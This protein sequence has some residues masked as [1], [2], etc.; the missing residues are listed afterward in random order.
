METFQNILN[1]LS[2]HLT[3]VLIVMAFLGILIIVMIVLTANR[4]VKDAI[5][6]EA[7]KPKKK[8]EKPYIPTKRMPPIGGRLTEKLS[9][10]GFFHVS[11]LSLS[12]LRALEY[13]R[14]VF[15]GTE[16]KYRLPWYLVLGASESGKNT[17]FKNA[18]LRYRAT[19]PDLK[20]PSDHP[21]LK[22]WFYNKGILLQPRGDLF[23]NKRG[24]A[25]ND[26]SRWRQLIALVARYRS[27]K[28]INGII[29]CI[30]ASEIYGINAL[31]RDELYDRAKF[32]GQKLQALQKDL[33]LRLPVYVIVTKCDTVRG[34]Q[35]V[36][37]EIPKTNIF[38]MLGWSNP[39]ALSTTY[40]EKWLDEG[41]DTLQNDIQKIQMEIYTHGKISDNREN[42]F[43]FFDEVTKLKDPLKIYLNAI[44]E[45]SYEEYLELRG[46]Y[47]TGDS[48]FGLESHLDSADVDDAKN[49]EDKTSAEA[50][51]N[52]V[53]SVYF[54]NDLLMEKVFSEGGLSEPA[55]SRLLSANR[56]L[57]V[58]KVSLAS[59]SAIS[60]I[61]LFSAYERLSHYSSKMLPVISNMTVMLS[62]HVEMSPETSQATR[63]DFEDQAKKLIEMMDHIH[64]AKFSSLF[65]PASWFS[66]FQENLTHS[67]KTAYDKIIIRSIYYDIIMRARGLI[68]LHPD[69]SMRSATL[70]QLLKPTT[71]KEFETLVEFLNQLK[72]ISDAA[73]KFNTISTAST[74]EV[75]NDLVMFTFN[76][77]L[78]KSFFE[79]YHRF[80]DIFSTID[81]PPIDFKKDIEK[82]RQAFL[83]VYVFFING[84]FN[85][86]DPFSI[87]GRLEYI[88]KT[89]SER[90][91]EALPDLKA[92]LQFSKELKDGIK[93]LKEPGKNWIDAPFFNPDNTDNPALT[94]PFG[95]FIAQITES[96]L[97]GKGIVKI[98]ADQTAEVFTLFQKNLQKNNKSLLK[99]EDIEDA[100]E[101]IPTSQGLKNL[102]DALNQLFDQVFMRPIK[103]REF[104]SDI[105][106]NKIVFW[107][108][109]LIKK[110]EE[111]AKAHDEYALKALSKLPEKLQPIVRELAILNT[112]N[113][114]VT[115]IAKAQT[116]AET[117]KNLSL[118]QQAEETLRSKINDLK[119]V[120][121]SFLQLLDV[122]NRGQMGP[123]YLELRNLLAPLSFQLLQ[124][125][126]EVFQSYKT[127]TIKDGNFDWWDG[128]LGCSYEAFR[129][130]DQEDLK[131][132]LKNQ[133]DIT[134]RWAIDFADLM[135]RFL[136]NDLVKDAPMDR[137]LI[138]KW[139]RLIEQ[140]RLYDKQIPDS[141]LLALEAFIVND[142]SKLSL[143]NIFDKIPI[144]D[145]A[146]ES[147][148][149]FKQIL[150]DIKKGMRAQAEIIKRKQVVKN[151][152]T[153]VKIFNDT[154]AQRFPFVR[155]APTRMETEAEPE[156][157]REF[158]TLYKNFGNDPKVILDQVH[159]MGGI[160]QNVLLF[161][162]RME[163][164][165]EF[166]ADYLDPNSLNDVPTFNFSVDFRTNRNAELGANLVVDWSF[167]AEEGLYI[168]NH[169]KER[170]GRWEFGEPVEFVFRWP[171]GIDVVPVKDRA[172]PVMS[173]ED[174]SAIFRYSQRWALLWM[175]RIQNA[176]QDANSKT[177]PTPYTLRFD[178]PLGVRKK[179]RIFNRITIL[180]PPKGKGAGKVL[181]VP[182]FPEQA[183]SLPEA[184]EETLT[185]PV[186]TY[187]LLREE[188]MA[189]DNDTEKEGN[190]SV[191][192]KSIEE[193]KDDSIEEEKKD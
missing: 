123:I 164:I 73:N 40:N 74:G 9:I 142:M 175:L 111:L 15:K 119:E 136:T 150:I 52:L 38:N 128:R 107:D 155:G 14:S 63:A 182:P 154:L 170:T 109:K 92:L 1:A 149:Y 118:G 87:P 153:L 124:R 26:E 22:W 167:S 82:I 106:P 116:I 84:L 24:A 166:F 163:K 129:V 192:K 33:G 69:H 19:Q 139:R 168:T 143:K 37:Q 64:Q 98:M 54:I 160:A 100:V 96:P 178:V 185:K 88:L 140:I 158:F 20:L 125:V 132:Y 34:F 8:E 130:K 61:G 133:A 39:Y 186:L 86:Q 179:A 93:D 187:G 75:L 67:L 50:S 4:S 56:S 29:L 35:S 36:C 97:L 134:R 10:K 41:F 18:T 31:S 148:D 2:K 91:T 79:K 6:K 173:V 46:F 103:V 147:G 76:T 72:S 28:P 126:E 191:E 99:K 43:F 146:D 11:E 7:L 80:R 94:G 145:V 70:S 53:K 110:A 51:Q 117:A 27:S 32:M 108:S 162:Q 113:H 114:V 59:F 21:P 131:V 12:I 13:L 65:M 48:G 135:V 47:L 104:R 141:S 190:D 144:S 68:Y 174:Q 101:E 115:L 156:D 49:L 5:K 184:I 42:L 60:T 172:Q 193:K 90:D 102:S 57:L 89:Y 165:K 180:Q 55:E 161:L 16:Y 151:Y 112:Q 17:L 85:P 183:P 62:Q 171:D 83:R 138:N 157:I 30:P 25:C 159:Q 137:A 105:P 176:T 121:E 188:D 23:I 44:F 95:E 189:I 152:N 78:P 45:H 58:S 169:D 81:Y 181:L 66:P 122:L 3:L 127:Y 177:D 77:E 120:V 71:S